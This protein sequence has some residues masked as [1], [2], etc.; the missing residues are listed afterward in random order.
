MQCVDKQDKRLDGNVAIVTGSDSG[1]GQASAKSFAEHGAD[2]AITWLEDEAGAQETGRAVE[3][4]GGKALVMRADV[5]DPAS[6]SDLFSR[7]VRELG[8]PYILV[9]DAGV[10]AGGKQVAEMGLEEWENEIRTNLTGPFLACQHFI[11]LRREAGGRGKIVNI[12]SVHE[13]TPAPERLATAPP[14][15]ACAT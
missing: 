14:R 12:T 6:V 7:T 1:I 8:V 2:V 3:A 11:R 13:D 10:D 5:R 9:N 4:A 15:A